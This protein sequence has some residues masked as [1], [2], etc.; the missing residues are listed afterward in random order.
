MSEGVHRTHCCLLHGC[1]Y[2]DEDCPVVNKRVRQAYP[3]EDCGVYHDIH[4][5]E[6]FD[7]CVRINETPEKEKR[8]AL[9]SGLAEINHWL[10]E[11]L[12]PELEEELIRK[13]DYLRSLMKKEGLSLSNEA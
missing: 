8:E 13:R 6:E 5:M 10:R 2:G 1:K 11:P 4:N 12:V 7:A 3:C 9:M